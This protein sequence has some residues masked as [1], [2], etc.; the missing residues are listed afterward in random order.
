[1]DA[2]AAVWPAGSTPDDVALRRVLSGMWGAALV[3]LLFVPSLSLTDGFAFDAVEGPASRYQRLVLGASGFVAVVGALRGRRVWGWVLAVAVP[4]LFGLGTWEA[5]S[6][7]G[8]WWAPWWRPVLGAG[9][10]AVPAW[11]LASRTPLR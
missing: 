11:L 1:M 2:N 6:D 5:L 10:V 3:A 8:V 9:L 7:P 4:V